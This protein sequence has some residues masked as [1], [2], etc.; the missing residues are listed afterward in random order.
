MSTQQLNPLTQLLLDL[1][2]SLIQSRFGGDVMAGG[3]DGCRREPINDLAPQGI[4]LTDRFYLV[5]KK[6]DTQ[7][8]VF[9]VGREDFHRIT[10][11]TKGAAVEIDVVASVLDIDQ[12][13]QQLVAIELHALLK[14]NQKA[15]IRLR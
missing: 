6:L 14:T 8:A 13:T 7:S 9:F 1:T 5:T 3:E 10:A 15:V 2:N 11:N 4:N 12:T